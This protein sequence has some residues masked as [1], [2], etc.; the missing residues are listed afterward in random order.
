MR[1][2]SFRQILLLSRYI[3]VSLV[4]HFGTFSFRLWTCICTHCT[5]DGSS[6]FVRCYHLGLDEDASCQTDVG[7]SVGSNKTSPDFMTRSPSP[8][9]S[10]KTVRRAKRARDVAAGTLSIEEVDQDDNGYDGDVEVV[11]ADQFEEPESESDIERQP[12]KLIPSIDE[13]ITRGMRQLGWRHPSP[14]HR[15]RSEDVM[16]SSGMSGHATGYINRYGKRPEAE[17][18][19]ARDGH[20]SHPPAPKRR[21]KRDPPP[22]SQDPFIHAS[23]SLLR[24]MSSSLT[25]GIRS[26]MMG[27]SSTSSTSDAALHRTAG[28]DEMMLD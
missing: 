25:G 17:T 11:Q 28:G 4:L 26:P 9:V 2:I 27:I 24:S 7:S 18:S 5:V 22:G 1:D 16:L 23:R 6:V 8:P 13:E 3:S 14:G 15:S 21:K 12:S 19:D 20:H 10:P